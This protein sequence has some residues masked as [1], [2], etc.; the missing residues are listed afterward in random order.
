M[1]EGFVY[2]LQTAHP[3]AK[4]LMADS[5]FWSPIEETAPFGNDSGWDASQGFREWRM[6]NRSG[7]PLLYLKELMTAWEFPSFDWYEMDTVKIRKFILSSPQPDEATVQERMKLFKQASR[8]SPDTSLQHITDTE[9]R[10]LVLSASQGMNG[11]FL[12]NQDN[13]IIGTGFAQLA[14]EGKV[15]KELKLLTITTIKRQLLPM[16]INRYDPGYLDTRKYQLTK[17]LEA[18]GKAE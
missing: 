11:T 14:L 12:L 16:L 9:L 18:M 6:R 15:D 1:P 13:A 8:N 4:M 10:Q 5:F 3:R 2:T 17:M 7:L